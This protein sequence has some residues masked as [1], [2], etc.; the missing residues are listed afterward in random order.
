MSGAD[1]LDSN[2]LIY[3]VD[4]RDPKKQAIAQRIVAEALIK[5]DAVISFQ[6][7]QETLNVLTRLAKPVLAETDAADFLDSVLVPMWKVQATP[8][9]YRSALQ[10]RAQYQ[11][12]FYD[13][14]VLAAAIEAG[15][16][17]LLTEDLQHGLKVGPLTVVDPFRR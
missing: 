14:L 8:E 6:I 15:C 11:H 7:V 1:F 10:L 16:R 17:R 5:G 12:S 9:L 4:R 3:A 13:S 2:I